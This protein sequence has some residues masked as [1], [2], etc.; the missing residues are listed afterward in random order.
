MEKP[1]KPLPELPPAVSMDAPSNMVKCNTCGFAAKRGRF[2]IFPN[3][4]RLYFELTH[5]ERLPENVPILCLGMPTNVS[6]L[7]DIACVRGKADLPALVR[8]RL[9]IINPT[10]GF[11]AAHE[12]Y[13]FRPLASKEILEEDRDCA[14]WYNYEPGRSPQEHLADYMW[15]QLE[16]QRQDFERDRE[17]DRRLFEQRLQNESSNFSNKL[18]IAALILGLAQFLA[19]FLA[20]TRDS[21][22]M[23]WWL[24]Q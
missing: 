12:E 21:F 10:A 3:P 9:Q 15:E 16:K 2:P 1:I 18:I 6:E 13:V 8:E 19:A 11:S 14:F 7:V 24:G 17:K 22:F 5:D 4:N 23:K 20:M